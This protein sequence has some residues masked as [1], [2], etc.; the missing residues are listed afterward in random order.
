L[1]GELLDA[2]PGLEDWAEHACAGDFMGHRQAIR[3]RISSRP[4]VG[5]E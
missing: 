5:A 4:I 3:D 2:T 1:T